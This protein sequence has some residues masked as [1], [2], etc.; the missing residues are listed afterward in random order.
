MSSMGKTDKRMLLV[1]FEKIILIETSKMMP[2]TAGNNAGNG[3]RH[4]HAIHLDC[5]EPILLDVF[6]QR[7]NGKNPK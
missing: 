2:E 1:V 4:A 3:R 6:T 7:H 5:P